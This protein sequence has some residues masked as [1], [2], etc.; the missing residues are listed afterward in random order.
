M[1]ST[2]PRSERPRKERR[3]QARAQRR[4]LEQ[5]QRR[6]V[7]RQRLLY[8]LGGALTVA[9][10][11]VIVLVAASSGG[12]GRPGLQQGS[13][14]ARTDTGVSTLL[15]GISQSGNVLG[16]PRAPVTMQYYGDLE[17]PVCQAFSLGTL[18]RL[19]DQQVRS[20]QLKIEYRSLQTATPS[21]ATFLDQQVAAVAAGEQNRLWNYVELFYQEQGQEGT[22]YVTDSY[23]RGLATQVP[24]LNLA[25]WAA[26][27]GDRALASQVTG[28][29]SAASRA[30]LT[31]T[32]AL[33]ITG[34]Q[35]TKYLSGDVPYA[36]VAAAVQS[37]A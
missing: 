4:A 5:A 35:G 24:G 10:L 25:A 18:P 1:S 29:E 20:G 19:I 31:A 33:V 32:P 12:E 9:L 34:P 2:R 27:R 36:T 7:A 6:R 17:C 3:E 22:G 37:V 16:D 28:S 21:P 30:G 15:R 13:Q 8:R 14:A 23:L 11:V 26:A